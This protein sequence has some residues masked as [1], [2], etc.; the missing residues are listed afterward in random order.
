MSA[1]RGEKPLPQFLLRRMVWFALVVALF[2]H[3]ARA[4]GQTQTQTD[5]AVH[6]TS[7]ARDHANPEAPTSLTD[8]LNEAERN[9]PQIEAARQGWQAAKQIPSQV[10]TLPDP[11]FQIQQLNV[12]SPRPLAGYT[13]SD[14]AYIGLGVS[15]DFPYP[16]KLKLKGEIAKRDADA[17]QQQYES[18]RRSVL[19]G[20]KSAYFQLAYLSKTL[21]ILE[22]DG[23]LLQQVE[24]AADARYRSGMGNQQDLLQSQVEETKLQREITMHHLEVAKAQAQ[25][26]ELLN[27]PQSSPDI[28]PADLVETPLPYTFDELLAATNAQNPEISGAKEMVEKQKLQIDLAH[29][30]FYPDFNVQYMWQRTDPTQFRAYYMLSVGVRVPIYRSRKQRPE[31][32]QAEADLN[33]ARS[34]Q[35]SQTQQVALE[36]RT[37]Y[38]T[39]EKTDELLKIYSD[40]LLPQTRA[41][42]QAGLA[43]YQNNRA[44][45]QGLLTSFLDVLHLDEEYWQSSA[46]RETALARLEELTGLSLREQGA[47]K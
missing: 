11:Q 5:E 22:S 4:F 41:E 3:A 28:V 36:V 47:T 14:F 21:A 24:K 29:K 25:I 16:G 32:A 10:S 40:G 26:K 17:M 45:F 31:L 35:E 46:D 8:L 1:L 34:E 9:N 39:V 44:D 23:Q 15:Q 33:R 6:V 42:F 38:D 19:T 18:M 27:R 20:V 43:S 37:E 7:A 12:G 2:A 30:D 13:N